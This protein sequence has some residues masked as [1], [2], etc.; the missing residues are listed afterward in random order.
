MRKSKY[1]KRIIS[2]LLTAEILLSF[3]M[4]AF[5]EEHK[6]LKKT[7]SVYVNTDYYGTVTK[8]NIYNNYEIANVDKILDHG[9]YSKIQVITGDNKPSISGD[10]ISWS[11]SG[12][13]K[14]G[15]IS[16]FKNL[17]LKKNL[18]WNVELSYYLNGV[19]TLAEELPHKSGLIKV[20]IKVIP[21][22]EAPEVYQNNYMMEVKASFDMS[23]YLSVTSNEAIEA[24]VGNTKSLTFIVLPGREKELSIEMGSD[25]FSMSGITFAM[26]PLEGDIL[27]LVQDVVEDRNNIRKALDTTNES[28]DV[29]LNQVNASTQNLDRISKSSAQ[30]NSGL[31]AINQNNSKRIDTIEELKG[32]LDLLSGDANKLD[33]DIAGAIQ[34]VDYLKGRTKKITDLI[35]ELNSSL[36]ELKANLSKNEKDL[37]RL[38]T[39]SKKLHSD[40]DTLEDLLIN[41]KKAVAGL[42]SL[43][44]EFDTSSLVDT[45]SL[46]SSLYAIKNSTESIAQE[47][48]A[49]LA[50][51]GEDQEFYM[52]VINTAKNIGSNL[53]KV[54]KNLSDTQ[55]AIE[56]ANNKTSSLSSSLKKLQESL[57]DSANAV[58][59]LSNYSEDVP[60][61]V[62]NLNNSIKSIDESINIITK[63]VD[64]NIDSDYAKMI[65]ELDDLKSSL[66]TLRSIKTTLDKVKDTSIN[67]LNILEGDLNETAS[68][69]HQGTSETIDATSDLMGNLKGMASQGGAL[70]NAKNQVYD[71]ITKDMDDLDNKTNIFKIN[72]DEPL[73]SFASEKNETPKKVQ[74]FI[75][76]DSIKEVVETSNVDLENEKEN[77]SFW[78]KLVLIFQKILAFFGFGKEAEW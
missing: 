75:Q 16:T 43:L 68:S 7:E 20:V 77:T 10:E 57:K 19:E 69:I 50:Q 78:D 12:D 40:L 55:E 9:D 31:N 49:R 38:E 3:T 23:K 17:D 28:L 70:R 2:L 21:N 8:M 44:G 18:P 61:T 63:Y 51:G 64:N 26:V 71:I 56:D 25:D 46:S 58:K 4:P 53:E 36:E 29:I 72:P 6:I 60:G 66:E 1:F 76:T 11:T 45:K 22:K 15:Y 54:S 67:A 35:K 52:D 24:Q 62:S 39:R 42:E 34:D 74:I 47:A 73:V 48:G 13:K 33:S 32:E 59:R 14:L 37:E 41:T 30:L 5:A 27:D 65:T